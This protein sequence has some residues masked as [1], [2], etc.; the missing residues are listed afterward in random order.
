VVQE[1]VVEADGGGL[2]GQELALSPGGA[3]AGD[4]EAGGLRSGGDEPEQQLAAGGLQGAN[5][6][7]STRTRS[8]A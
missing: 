8:R 3:M 4:A 7:S 1:P 5:P 6:S 2:V